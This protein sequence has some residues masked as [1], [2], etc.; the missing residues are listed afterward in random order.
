M[1]NKARFYIF[2]GGGSGGHLYPGLAVAEALREVDPAGQVVFL[3]TDRDIDKRI[4]GEADWQYVAQPVVPMALGP[5]GLLNF[6]RRWQESI[7]CCELLMRRQ[8]P[9]VVLGLGGFASAPALKVAAKL[10]VPAAMLN[11]DATPGKANRY[12]RR[13]VDRIFLQWGASRA[14]FGRHQKKCVVVGCPIRRRILEAHHS[15]RSEMKARRES[16]CRA[17]GMDADRRTLVVMGGSQGG[18]NINAAVT[19]LACG[20][21]LD[22]FPGAG[23][24]GPQGG[25]GLLDQDG[26]QIL[27]IA[28]HE[29]RKA[30]ADRYATTPGRANV[31]IT[32]FSRH[33]E[34]VLTAADLVVARAGA[35]TLAELMA[36]GT[37]SILLPYPYHR[38][39]HQLRNAEL[40]AKAE[41][42]KIVIDDGDT[43]R[44]AQRLWE[45]LQP[46]MADHRALGR[47]GHAARSLALPDAARKVAR[48]II[49]LAQPNP[50]QK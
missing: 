9:A 25:Q 30:V 41:A 3:A 4:L 2:A 48:E 6:Y 49:T 12:C 19:A 39:Q 44:T 10:K 1:T 37:P 5:K 23:A 40:L 28:G 46:C 18:H 43:V 27:H 35:S 20:N 11:I 8:R 13:Y 16:A 21:G 47:M 22:Q 45:T 17:L 31:K 34:V 26:W 42:A 38:D 36:T 33:M 15:D 50:I 24:N 29:E 14:H 7:S 32:A